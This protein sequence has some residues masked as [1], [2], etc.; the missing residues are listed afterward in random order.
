[1]YP[2]EYKTIHTRS[3]YVYREQFQSE[4]VCSRYSFMGYFL[5]KGAIQLLKF[6]Q[7]QRLFCKFL[8]SPFFFFFLLFFKRME[9]TR[10]RLIFL[11]HRYSF[12]HPDP[13]ILQLFYDSPD[14]IVL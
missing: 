8:F 13:T 6:R 3:R 1:M 11:F 14:P 12:S 7:L 10:I 9:I 4:S 5:S 2:R